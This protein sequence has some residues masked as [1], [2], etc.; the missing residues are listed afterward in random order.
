MRDLA[1]ART[2]NGRGRRHDGCPDCAICS[3]PFVAGSDRI[4]VTE[5]SVSG[6]A[7]TVCWMSVRGMIDRDDEPL[8]ELQRL[9]KKT[10]PDDKPLTPED[11]WLEP[12]CPC[13]RCR[14]ME[15][16]LWALRRAGKIGPGSPMRA[17]REREQRACAGRE[18]TSG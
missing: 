12:G 1:R 9:A 11:C 18:R 3:H 8:R 13:D 15:S 5:P 17:E 7:H 2:K 4:I 6:I 10:E 14:M 16:M